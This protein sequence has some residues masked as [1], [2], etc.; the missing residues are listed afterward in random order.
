MVSGAHD[1]NRKKVPFGFGEYNLDDAKIRYFVIWMDAGT[2]P[3]HY[4]PAI[5]SIEKFYR[6]QNSIPQPGNDRYVYHYNLTPISTAESERFGWYETTVGPRRPSEC[7]EEVHTSKKAV[8]ICPTPYQGTGMYTLIDGWILIGVDV[9]TNDTSIDL[10]Q[11][12]DV[13]KLLD[14]LTTRVKA[15]PLTQHDYDHR[16]D[17]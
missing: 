13:D 1:Y 3:P 14:A 17:R 12:V 4:D 9:T 10:K 6:C 16:K 7:D 8:G 11:V 15:D 5:Y 2:R